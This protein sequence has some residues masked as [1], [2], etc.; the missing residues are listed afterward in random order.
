MTEKTDPPDH[1]GIV[2]VTA[3][4]PY[5]WIIFNA[6]AEAFGP[7]TVIEEAPEPRSVFLRRRLR[8]FGAVTTLGQFAM[9]LATR[10]GKGL[11]AGRAAAIIAEHE[12]KP[13]PGPLLTR[14]KVGSIN[15]P[16]TRALLAELRPRVVF[17][18]G[19]RLLTAQ[20][21]ESL[22]CPVLNY[23][24]GICPAYRGLNGG[25]FAL[26]SGDAGNF[27][28]TIHLV[29]E[30]VDTGA[31]LHHQRLVPGRRDNFFTYALVMAAGS[32]A[33]AVE[34][35]GAAL[36]GRVRPLA[37]EMASRQWFHPTLWGYLWTG[38]RRGVW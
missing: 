24:A 3:G 5:A 28:T 18:A 16:E 1:S 32:R 9:M 34:G 26:A 4:G 13:E 7:V 15:D 6:L 14:V 19:C 37:V 10:I 29:D 20:T 23:H 22:P 27:G 38:L 31:I 25:Y 12:L 33:I 30:G 21:L 2:A 11:T 17:L 35:V 36:A 8:K